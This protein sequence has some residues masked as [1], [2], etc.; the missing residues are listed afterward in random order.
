MRQ[1]KDGEQSLF[2]LFGLFSLLIL[3]VS[4]SLY[5][6]S[7][8]N[9][10]KTQQQSF[11]AFQDANDKEF[12]QTIK[13][14]WSEYK[15]QQAH[16]L[17][18]SPKPPRLP[19]AGEQQSPNVGPKIY[20][21]IPQIKEITKPVVVPKQS[22][23]YDISFDFFGERLGFNVYAA[24]KEARYFPRDKEGITNFFSTVAQVDVAPLVEAIKTKQKQLHLNDWGV[25][26]VLRDLSKHLYVN[27][28]EQK[29]MLWFLLNKLGYDIKVALHGKRVLVMFY[30]QK[31]IYATP[32]YLFGQKRY[33]LLSH[34]AKESVGRVYSYQKSYPHA[35]KPFDLSLHSLPK[36]PLNLHKKTLHFVYDGKKQSISFR[37]NQNL[38]DFMATYPQ[39]NY[40]T[41]FT[42][43]LEKITYH[44]LLEGLKRS[45][46]AQK[47][48]RGIDFLLKLVQKSF[49]Y[50]VDSIQFGREKVMFAQETLVYNKSDCED[51]AILFASLVRKIFH[52]NVIGIRYKDHMATA[53]YVPLQGDFVRYGKRK[54]VVADPTYVN[55]NIG[56]SMPQ[57]KGVAP[58]QFIPL[59]G[60]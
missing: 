1:N 9:F 28:D 45:F 31:T 40:A 3:F 38:V 15:A 59:Q 26:L 18:A 35:I 44:D 57:Y 54:F 21:K 55:A 52:I 58:Q 30:S 32:S 29:L 23:S 20:F 43:P 50:E 22:N 4:T 2:N 25:Y 53:L 17:Y 60:R 41:Y 42:A 47:A 12:F 51:R 49:V 46:N 27:E 14:P 33:Y 24:L 39:A 56:Q 7:F 10:K 36:L 13:A 5:G 19:K 37:Y 34:Y 11:A 48:S 8:A 6:E 16:S